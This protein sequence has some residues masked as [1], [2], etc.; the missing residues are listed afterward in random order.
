MAKSKH[1]FEDYS[2]INYI[3]NSNKHSNQFLMVNGETV[4]N[5][6]NYTAVI[7]MIDLNN[8]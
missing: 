2:I 7:L 4:G 3:S 1:I 6:L 5:V 8:L